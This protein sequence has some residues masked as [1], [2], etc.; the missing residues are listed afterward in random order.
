MFANGKTD[1]EVAELAN[2]ARE[3]HGNDVQIVAVGL[4]DDVSK[5]ELKA[6]A[7]VG[8]ILAER[9]QD[10]DAIALSVAKQLDMLSGTWSVVCIV[11]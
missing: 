1:A 5:E 8:L 11:R 2:E 3:L 6:V 10:S 4:G 9:D 7:N